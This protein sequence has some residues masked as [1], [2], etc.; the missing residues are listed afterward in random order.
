MT[1]RTFDEVSTVE[2]ELSGSLISKNPKHRERLP[3]RW[4]PTYYTLA[5]DGALPSGHSNSLQTFTGFFAALVNESSPRSTTSPR[6]SCIINARKSRVSRSRRRNNPQTS[7]IWPPSTNHGSTR[8][9]FRS[10][11][12]VV[13]DAEAAERSRWLQHLAAMIVLS[14][15]P[16]DQLLTTQR[17][18]LE[19]SVRVVG[20]EPCGPASEVLFFF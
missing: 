2:K 14:P 9:G 18:D 8:R 16:T 11:C 10:H 6:Q 13:R 5:N 1:S 12:T 15:T 17:G 4:A 7:F 20:L 3:V 19:L